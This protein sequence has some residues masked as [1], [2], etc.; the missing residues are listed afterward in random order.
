MYLKDLP[1]YDNTHYYVFAGEEGVA[2]YNYW[3][4][5]QVNNSKYFTITCKGRYNGE[6]TMQ[7]NC[8]K[9]SSFIIGSIAAN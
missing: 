3:K 2:N 9:H 5:I 4:I 7:Y 1:K 6:V 8:Y